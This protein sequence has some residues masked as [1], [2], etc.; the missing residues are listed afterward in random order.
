MKKVFLGLG[1]FL[2][3]LV[4]YL[5][6]NKKVNILN[7]LSDRSVLI[8][9]EKEIKVVGFLPTWM[10][11]K[12]M[13]YTNEIDELIFLGIEVDEKGNLIWDFQSKKI[14]NESYLKQK[15]LIW[16][17]GGKNILG[18]KLFKD[19]KLDKLINSEE[20]QINLINQLRELFK[21]DKFDGINVD[22]EYQGNP[23]AVLSEKFII[24]LNRLK[25]ENLGEISL[26]V[27][28]N[29]IIK[30][31]AEQINNLIGSVDNV[32]V[33]AYDFH[34][35]GVDYAG[36][37]API[38]S[39]PGDRNIM[40]VVEKV[41]SLNLNREKII[42]AYPLYGYEW[43]TYTKDFESQIKRGWYQMASWTRV[44]DL[45]ETADTNALEVKWDE[46]SMTPWLVFEKEG[47]IHQIYFENEKSLGLKIDLVR[48]NQF[49]GV[50]FWALGY[51]GED[52]KVW[53]KVDQL[54]E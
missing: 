37:V 22:F 40:G 44:K 16:K 45:I 54:L 17:N 6:W 13:E 2:I 30:G 10:V 36:A 33:M 29:T 11:G 35:P 15:D 48:Q 19:E 51:E 12:T 21:T 14:N 9:K 32:I 34:R 27:F 53:Q 8:K 5:Y 28:A 38:N 43:K 46:L 25:Q 7:P 42:M 18:I 50:G 1:L 24:F 4:G 23:T 20:A 49:G 52:L 3:I 39:Q 41:L 26:D 47:E 31:S